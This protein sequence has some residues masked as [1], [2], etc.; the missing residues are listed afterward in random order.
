MITRNTIGSAEGDLRYGP[1]GSFGVTGPSAR[2]PFGKGSLGIQVSDAATTPIAGGFISEKVDYGNEVAFFGD[3][4][5]AL[6]QVGFHMFQTG[7]NVTY[8]G[9]R[10]MP[11]IRFEIDANLTVRVRRTTTPP[12][13]GCPTRRRW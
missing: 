9:P 8:G 2:S 6:N 10:N 1:Y 3:P 13:Y 11:N 5:L 4:V 7:E 12:W